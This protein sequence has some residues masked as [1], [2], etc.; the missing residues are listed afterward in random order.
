MVIILCARIEQ[1][2]CKLDFKSVIAHLSIV[3]KESYW[4]QSMSVVHRVCRQQ[5]EMTTP[6][7]SQECSLYKSKPNPSKYD[8]FSLVNIYRKLL[9]YPLEPIVRIEYNLAG[10]FSR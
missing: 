10:I 1:K 9:T 7:Y 6:Q 5:L 2:F 4:D 3:L 8:T